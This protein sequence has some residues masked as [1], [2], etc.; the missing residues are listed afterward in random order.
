[1]KQVGKT[2][3]TLLLLIYVI[4]A[5]A[6]E[7][8]NFSHMGVAEGLSQNTVFDIAQDK[9]GFMW[10]ATYNGLNKYDGYE[11]RIYQHVEND[12]TS[13]ANS[14]IRTV[15]ADS[16]GRVWVGTQ[17]GLSL[18]NMEK[19]SFVNYKPDN[20]K[21]VRINHI[22][23]IDEHNLLLNTSG[24]LTVFDTSTGTF[25]TNGLHPTLFEL[26][27]R[28]IYRYGDA[29]YIGARNGLFVYSIKDKT[30]VCLYKDISEMSHIQ[31][32]LQQSAN[33]LWIG[34]EGYGLFLLNPQTGKL[35]CYRKGLGLNTDYIR[36]LALD[37]DN[38]LWVGAL[39]ALYIYDE[40]G[41]KF[42]F[43]TNDPLKLNSLSH[44]S[45][46]C[47]Y[48]DVQG[49]M[50]LGTYFG[51]LNYYHPLKDR[52]KNMFRIPHRNTLND[53]VIGCIIE[54]EDENL[55]IGTNNGGINFYNTS[56]GTFSY[57]TTKDGLMA[58][59]IKTL[60][61]DKEQKRIYI[62]THA[63]GLNI[64]HLPGKR[65]ETLGRTIT[66]GSVY[67][68]APGKKG[69]L[70][71][72]GH[73]GLVL[74]NTVNKVFTPVEK[75]TNGKPIR[76]SGV[77]NIIKDSKGR[78]WVSSEGGLDVYEEKEN[79]IT[80]L[81]VI[82]SGSPLSSL[83][84]NSVYE[85]YNGTFWV[86][87][88]NGVYQIDEKKQEVKH[89]DITNGLS[90]N[91]VYGVL[92]DTF[93]RL[94]MSTD[95]GLSCLHPQ[96]GIFRNY[97]AEDG[98][99]S[100]QFTPFAYCHR[101]NGELFF[102]GINGITT[103]HPEHMPETPFTPQVIL[104]DFKLFDQPVQAHDQTGILSRHISNTKELILSAEQ[105]MFAISF[106]VPD[107]VSETRSLFAYKLEGYDRDWI[108]Q[109]H[110]FRS[111]S[112]SNLPAGSYRFL[113][114]AS[115][116]DG[117]WNENPTEL[118]ITIL[119]Y[120]YNTW[121]ARLLFL[122]AFAGIM[123]GIF[124]LLWIRKSMRTQLEFERRDKERQ[125]EMNEMKMRFFINM[126]H[127]LRTPLTLITGPVQAVLDTVTDK[128]ILQ[129]MDYVKRSANR[130][131]HIVNQLMDYRRAELGVF[132]LKVRKTDIHQLVRNLFGQYEQVA[133]SKGISYNLNSAI[134]GQQLLCDPHYIELIVNNL[135][136][137]AFKHT[138]RDESITVKLCTD[139]DN[140]IIEVEDTG[141]GIPLEEQPKI[142]ERFYH[143]DKEHF[144]SGVGLSL[145]KRLVD[146]HH[147]SI[148]LDSAEGKGSTFTITLPLSESAYQA[149]E[150]LTE[151]TETL[152]AYSNPEI[153]LTYQPEPDDSI[154]ENSAGS[155]EKEKETILIVE[156]NI[157]IRNFLGQE[158]E[159]HFKVLN[160]ADG[161]EALKIVRETN[162]DLVCT[163]VMM[164]KMNGV[165]LCK[166]IKQNLQTCHIPVVIL[167]A[168]ADV[169]HQMEGL[170][171][172]A[173]DYIAKP[174]VISVVVAKIRNILRT[175]YLSKENYIKSTEIKPEKMALNTMDEDLLKRA[176]KVVEAHMDD[177]EFSTDLFASELNMSRSNL[178][179]KMK[180]LTG[181][182]A[183]DFIRKIRLGHA[184]RLLKTGQYTVA[185]ISV[186]AGFNTPSY[187]STSFKKY[188][189]CLPSE[190]GRKEG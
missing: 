73:N 147:G 123:F 132:G 126:S 60:Y 20:T 171:V 143:L 5:N 6:K 63:G 151:S 186:M 35:K 16:R 99:Q 31:T 2:L 29:I 130:L 125:Q 23:E 102:G 146:L 185:E 101:K 34:T 106:V 22:L 100:N 55:W 90:D 8:I 65:L 127:E 42:Q 76:N 1:M 158:L 169:R 161:E 40:E 83:Y 70:W 189:G 95:K 57:I 10:F 190:Y 131:L 178:H 152:P 187:F 111:A 142:F 26:K 13:I 68:I 86:C 85:S 188:F 89:Y 107:Y 44:G 74:F 118:N 136:S 172:G 24:G 67:A 110:P 160:A 39:D 53:N 104:T 148:K 134:T 19:N 32:L 3:L 50:W 9:H 41:D 141:T 117:R 149:D 170:K 37:M 159:K 4:P 140:L 54:D 46:R 119:P 165:E 173:D 17:N 87:T 27:A 25:T 109:R 121:W 166:Q 78:L 114:K 163:D 11:F 120:W 71:L 75:D 103:F 145:V 33:K 180:A 150:Y 38:N 88:R 108:Y 59:D 81:P 61:I 175:H 162:I 69:S 62:G 14:I 129:Q 52:F 15:K 91:V 155:E 128:W 72:G 176:V 84:T 181:E 82:D 7:S 12:S 49:G 124:R 94:W 43:H 144:S 92:E 36:S 112:Y 177:I 77:R 116:R 154:N 96:T 56:T 135:L 184:C 45:V 66:N 58:N 21:P 153:D 93:G 30:L 80:L 28:M 98:I 168:R 156:D 48:K 157:D 79:E 64:L 47:I 138:K 179:L 183:S 137:N 139:R 51:G 105:S 167:S 122:L 164:P 115:N 113:V 18:Y 182:G 133:Q 97:L 174:F